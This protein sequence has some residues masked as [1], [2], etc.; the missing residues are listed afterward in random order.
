[1]KILVT[2]ANGLV[3]RACQLYAKINRLNIS[4]ISRRNPLFSDIKNYKS[5]KELP[6]KDRNF[7]L[8]IHCSAATPNNCEFEEIF[9]TNK[10]IDEELCD[11]VLNSS[12]KQVVYLSTMAVYGEIYVKKLSERTKIINPNLYGQ[13]KYIGEN[14]IKQTCE[15]KNIKLAIIRLPGVVGKDMPYIFFRRVY[16]SILNSRKI[17]I[18]SRHALFNNAIL[19]KDI[20]FTS[21]Y[22]YEKQKDNFILLN[23]HSENIITLGK[24]LD[25]FERIVGKSCIFEENIECNPP[26]LITNTMND[27]LLFK[28]N[29]HNMIVHF[30]ETYE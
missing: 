19:D 28:S 17:S 9:N 16:E 15:K 12:V 6:Q 27:D 13:S 22:L 3:G 20:F 1:M 2:G 7:D 5:L 23:H 30:H 18:R 11:F 24:L 4:I 25:D 8:V 10:K 21:I 14:R 26:F 29:I